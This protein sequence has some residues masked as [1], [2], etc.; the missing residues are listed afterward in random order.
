ML[1]ETPLRT[2]DDVTSDLS[3]HVFEVLRENAVAF[4]T[5]EEVALQDQSV[6]SA[7]RRVVLVALPAG[8]EIMV[9]MEGSGCI[10]LD[11]SSNINPFVF[12]G[13]GFQ[14]VPAQIMTKLFV[15]IGQAR[16]RLEEHQ[17]AYP[18]LTHQNRS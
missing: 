8:E 7:V 11:R 10:F 13:A 4:L 9:A 1:N 6:P 14:M 15:D 17:R 18:Q 12:V 2:P 3:E 5:I 16:A